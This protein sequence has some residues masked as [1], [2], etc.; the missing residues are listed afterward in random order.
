MTEQKFKATWDGKPIDPKPPFGAAIVVYR[1]QGGQREYLILHRAHQ[2]PDFEGDWA[3]TPPS[4]ARYPGETIEACA[5][6][7]LREEIGLQ[8]DLQTTEFGD[9]WAVFYAQIGADDQIELID[10]EHDRYEW[11]SLAEAVERCQPAQV[12]QALSQV[13]T[14]L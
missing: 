6:R 7:E 13:A 11:V 1:E 3:W 12:S 10:D 9:A 4:G 2:G 14:L 5:W 8:L